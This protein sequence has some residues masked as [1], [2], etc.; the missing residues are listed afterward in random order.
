MNQTAGCKNTENNS[1]NNKSR[2]LNVAVLLLDDRSSTISVIMHKKY[3][4]ETAHKPQVAHIKTM[5]A[6]LKSRA[7][8]DSRTY[9]TRDEKQRRT[10]VQTEDGFVSEGLR[11]RKGQTERGGS[12]RSRRDSKGKTQRALLDSKAACG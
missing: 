5:Q 2:M 8:S 3:T 10:D 6:L 11:D 1:M 7:Q 4:T 9:L 12:L